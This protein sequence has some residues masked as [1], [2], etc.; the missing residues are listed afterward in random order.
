MGIFNSI[1]GKN[2]NEETTTFPWVPLESIE[3]LDTIVDESKEQ[4]VAIF[5]HSVRCGISAMVKRGFENHENSNSGVKLYYLDLITYRPIS[6]EIADRF[7]VVHE[8]PQLIIIKNGEAIK[9]TS[10]G[11]INDIDLSQF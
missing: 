7:G 1:F 6:N 10:H 5:K 11:S 2:S 9:A 8:S 4:V 3:Q